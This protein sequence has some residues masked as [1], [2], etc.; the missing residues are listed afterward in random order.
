MAQSALN[1]SPRK[2][3]LVQCMW[4]FNVPYR[5]AHCK[6]RFL[7]ELELVDHHRRQ[8]GLKPQSVENWNPA[9]RS[10]GSALAGPN[11]TLGVD[12]ACFLCGAPAASWG[13]I[14]AHIDQT[15]DRSVC[16]NCGRL[17]V[18]EAALQSH[19][20][21]MHDPKFDNRAP[22][23]PAQ[24][25]FERNAASN[26][27]APA[28]HSAQ[29]KRSSSEEN[30]SKVEDKGS[31]SSSVVPAD[32]H[33]C[34]ICGQSESTE[35]QGLNGVYSCA[36]CDWRTL[37]LARLKLHHFEDHDNG[38]YAK[39][40][41]QA[42]PSGDVEASTAGSAES[43]AGNSRDVLPK[44]KEDAGH[45]PTGADDPAGGAYYS[46]DTI[47]TSC[48]SAV[49][50]SDFEDEEELETDDEVMPQI[51][52][53]PKLTCPHCE[54]TCIMPSSLRRHHVTKHAQMPFVEPRD[55]DT[56]RKR[57]ASAK[58]RQAPRKARAK[59]NAKMHGYQR[60]GFVCSDTSEES[61]QEGECEDQDVASVA[62]AAPSPLSDGDASWHPSELSGEGTR[63]DDDSSTDSEEDE[64]S[65]VCCEKCDEMFTSKSKLAI[66][67]AKVH[68][69]R[70]FCFHCGRASKQVELLRLH[71]RREHRKR[72][73]KYLT[74]DGLKLVTVAY[75]DSGDNEEYTADESTCLIGKSAQH[76]T[77]H[78]YRASNS[79]NRAEKLSKQRSISR[80]PTEHL[81]SAPRRRK[82]FII[83]SSSDEDEER[84]VHKPETVRSISRYVYSG[85]RCPKSAGAFYQL[86]AKISDA[87]KCSAF[88]C[89]FSTNNASDFEEHLKG[90]NLVDVF[91]MYCGI[92]VASPEALITHLGQDHGSLRHQCSK[93]LYRSGESMHFKVH[94]L[95]AHPQ[96]TPT[97]IPVSYQEGSSITSSACSSELRVFDPYV[98]GFPGC[99]FENRK[100]S[101]FER[102]FEEVHVEANL[103]PCSVCK[104][105]CQSVAALVHHLQEHGFANVQCGYCNFGTGSTGAMMLHAC[106]CHSDQ[107][108]VFRVRSENIGEELITHSEM[109]VRYVASCDLGHLSFQQ[110]CCFCPEMVSGFD[111][112][113]R[114]VSSQ[115]DLSLSVEELA[116]RL[117]AA[118]D[119]TEA[120]KVSQ[121]P[122]CSFAVE[123][124][125]RLQ[126]HVLR[127]ELGIVTFT[128]S[129]CHSGFDDQLS[130]Q[131]HIESGNCSAAATMQLCNNGPVLLWSQQNLKFQIHRF[132][133]IYCQE[134][135]TAAPSFRAHLLRHYTYYPAECK[136]CGQKFRGIRSKEEHMRKA[137]GGS[138][139]GRDFVSC[140]EEEV[141][142]QTVLH[143]VH[144][145]P[146]CN[147]KSLNQS[148][149]T[150]HAE[151]C[152]SSVH[153]VPAQRV[154][155]GVSAT[156]N[157]YVDGEEE[158]SSIYHCMHCSVGFIYL[159]RLLGH[160]FSQHGC[161]YF[162]SSCYKGF[163]AK[164]GF[165]QHCK[166]R[167]CKRPKSML[168]V[169]AAK[170]GSKR[171][172]FFKEIS[173]VY[174]NDGD[175]SSGEEQDTDME[176]SGAFSFY[177]QSYEPVKGIERAYLADNHGTKLSLQDVARV[178]NIE[179]Y[180]RIVDWKRSFF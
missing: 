112:F 53:R 76:S 7:E 118:Y 37:S 171:T 28:S 68:R 90:H 3:A 180:V 35:P 59:G 149:A 168:C 20:K 31:T 18:S 101:D 77:K 133:C 51:T 98:C 72:A 85:Y 52:K 82:R 12:Y 19:R 43:L 75:V 159:Q 114:H 158:A 153:V 132:G 92:D 84:S 148:Y 138:D 47:L 58:V 155:S 44:C 127:Q 61:S 164:D 6:L 161:S 113:Q 111:N 1:P 89:G 79:T 2:S 134:T 139:T 174:D 86:M 117:F 30:G 42:G 122:F 105:G 103:F 121:C 154:E 95:Q 93:C 63:K 13:E 119:Y 142:R 147:F 36:H 129:A 177:N 96:D 143:V 71:H 11:S 14:C 106:Y 78:R 10:Y 48:P 87:F 126:K 124:A 131:Q 9:E 8:H 57:P 15:H 62:I 163:K 135:F 83:S 178:L 165:V 160:G 17:F 56:S 125:S 81:H 60:D 4:G 157:M 151:R 141:A 173:I 29:E 40:L 26:I 144:S 110:R 24:A 107:R 5:C 33:D 145:C 45:S 136:I 39:L 130:F 70:Y 156:G 150:S 162:C 65:S 170:K 32:R 49:D 23:A 175:S 100:R 41:Q 108:T 67:M 152:A 80:S 104:K 140:V 66:H 94:F 169:E 137:H 167:M 109:G 74:L 88:S 146:Y 27:A 25:T 64:L 69:L 55:R 120:V 50:D 34:S 16:R 123:S 179:P 166:G 176:E 99:S 91:C 22:E 46:D 21:N 73:F 172:Y 38:E 54:F 116:D 128:C 115:H 102:H 97:S